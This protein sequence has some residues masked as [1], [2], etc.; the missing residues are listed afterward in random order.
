GSYGEES[1][2]RARDGSW[3][4]VRDLGHAV[5][6]T[7]TTPT[8]IRG[9]MVDITSSRVAERD[10]EAMEGRFQRVIEHLP[11]IVYLEAVTREETGIGE[12]LYVSPQV[13]EILGFSPDEWLA[14]PVAWARQFHPEGRL[15]I[16]E[17]DDPIERNRGPVHTH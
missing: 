5:G 13:Q 3:V 14:D 4:W 17:E 10:R 15:R 7:G 1:R 9:L 11:A 12:M 2:L 6:E 16:P 8:S